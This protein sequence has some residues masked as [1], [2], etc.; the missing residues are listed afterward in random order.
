MNTK[1]LM[2]PLQL[3]LLAFTLLI[4]LWAPAPDWQQ[5]AAFALCGSGRP[6]AYTNGSMARQLSGG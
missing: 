6:S 2:R 1:N 3:S 5:A 4:L